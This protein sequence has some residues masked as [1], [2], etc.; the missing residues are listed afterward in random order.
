M[1]QLKVE[2]AVLVY[3]G[4]LAN[5]FSVQSFNM[6]PQGRQAKLLMQ[7]A[8]DRCEAFARGLVAAGAEVISAQCNQAGNIIDSVWSEDLESAPFSARFSPV[9]SNAPTKVQVFFDYL[10]G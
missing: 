8:F 6:G 10:D 4:G 2:K 3:Q 7:H 5:V 9:F 1:A